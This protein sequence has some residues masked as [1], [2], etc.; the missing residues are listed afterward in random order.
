MS[1]AMSGLPESG[2]RA[3]IGSAST[4]IAAIVSAI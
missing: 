4:V 1:A 3:D 2:R